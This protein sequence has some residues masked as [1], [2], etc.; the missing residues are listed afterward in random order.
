[1]KLNANVL[2]KKLWSTQTLY[3]G[4]EKKPGKSAPFRTLNLSNYAL[5]RNQMNYVSKS[6]S[7]NLKKKA[8]IFFCSDPL[9]ENKWLKSSLVKFELI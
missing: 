1:M 6:Q 4:M 8:Q 9:I 3:F 2:G 5:T 7:K